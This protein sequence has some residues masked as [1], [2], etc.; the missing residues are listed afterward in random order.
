MNM[1][2][3]SSKSWNLSTTVK[4]DTKELADKFKVL[5]S[6]LGL[7]KTHND[8]I[9]YAF[10][11]MIYAA[12]SGAPV[13][14]GFLRK[15]IGVKIRHYK[16]SGTSIGV[17]YIAKADKMKDRYGYILEHGAKKHRI[18]AIR[19]QSGRYAKSETGSVLHPG[20]KPY[21]FMREAIMQEYQR[22]PQYAAERIKELVDKEWGK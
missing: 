18:P 8:V 6:A 19:T 7:A 12:K 15:N 9:R 5:V 17:M 4:L 11:P 3:L 22:V 1:P 13:R 2:G 21:Q 14:T 10:A 16:N 20:F